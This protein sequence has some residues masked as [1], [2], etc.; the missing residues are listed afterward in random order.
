MISHAVDDLRPRQVGLHA[1]CLFVKEIAPAADC[2]CKRNDNSCKIGSRKKAFFVAP[3]DKISDE[4]TEDEPAVNRKSA[5]A[6]VENFCPVS[7][8]IVPLEDD[9]ICSCT[10][11]RRRNHPQNQ[12]KN[13][14]GIDAVLR[15]TLIRDES[16]KKESETDQNPIPG[17]IQTKY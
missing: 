3:A 16:C 4:K 15:C 5:S 13:E 12:I 14:V 17:N 6:N 7:R 8:I 11:N 9:I 2:L 10:D 1:V